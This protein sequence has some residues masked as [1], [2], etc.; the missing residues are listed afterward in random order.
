[1]NRASLL[2]APLA[3]ALAAC[4]SVVVV[5]VD[6]RADA[7]PTPDVAPTPD[8]VVPGDGG[9]TPPPPIDVPP[10]PV[11][12][13]PPPVDVPPPDV[14]PPPPPGALARACQNFCQRGNAVCGT[15]A[16]CA[17]LCRDALARPGVVRCPAEALA[18]LACGFSRNAFVCRPSRNTFELDT[19][20]CAGPSAAYERCANGTPPPPPVDGGT[21]P[22][23]AACAQ[24]CDRT[25]RDCGTAS[26]N[27]VDQCAMVSSAPNYATCS[28]QVLAVY[29]CVARNG[30]TCGPMGMNQP[31]PAC[32][33]LLSAA[34]MCLTGGVDPPP[35]PPPPVDGGPAPTYPGCAEACALA[36]RACGLSGTTCAADCSDTGSMLSGTCRRVFDEMLA[37]VRRNGFT[38]RGGSPQI[39]SAC[40]ALAMRLQMCGGGGGSTPTVDAGAPDR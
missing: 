38:C 26:S 39:A 18:M 5:P 9:V 6:P 22:L 36:D 33:P 17:A 15:T 23:R 24:V 13:P 1:M 11:D 34:Q 20:T 25:A 12:V 4:G 3:A 21:D 10:P 19:A 7:A 35:P 28:A 27:C 16:D 37:C 30:L 31:A 14:A 40:D 8:A 2:F 32:A 29:D